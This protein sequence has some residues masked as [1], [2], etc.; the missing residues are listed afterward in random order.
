MTEMFLQ[1]AIQA[2]ICAAF[3]VISG[4]RAAKMQGKARRIVVLAY[5]MVALGSVWSAAAPYLP[6]H[7]WVLPWPTL[8][9]LLGLLI[10][11]S[12]ASRIWRESMPEYLQGRV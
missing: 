6:A 9:L 5:S 4:C 10:V 7:R 1:G 8:T 12:L 2:L 3:A 11:M